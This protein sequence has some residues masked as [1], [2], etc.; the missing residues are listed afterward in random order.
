MFPL[1]LSDRR[2]DLAALCRGVP[3]AADEVFALQARR[4]RLWGGGWLGAGADRRGAAS[5][6]PSSWEV[7]GMVCLPEEPREAERCAHL[8]C[9]GFFEAPVAGK[10]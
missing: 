4:G 1:K 6:G 8:A 5:Q 10:N 7:Q 3:L 9:F 2:S